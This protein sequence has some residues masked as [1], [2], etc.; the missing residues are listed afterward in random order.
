MRILDIN[1]QAAFE[2][3]CFR[4]WLNHIDTRI[5]YDKRFATASVAVWRQSF[6]EGM[7]E[8]DAIEMLC[9]R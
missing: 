9:G 7:Y 4:D 8:G 2:N 6:E 3:E 1:N 5:G